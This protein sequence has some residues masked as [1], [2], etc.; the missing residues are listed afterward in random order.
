[1]VEAIRKQNKIRGRSGE[2]VCHQIHGMGIL[3]IECFDSDVVS[4]TR[5][6]LQMVEVDVPLKE[7]KDIWFVSGSDRVTTQR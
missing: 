6:E 1:L 2:D 3:P 4:E 7:R 5:G